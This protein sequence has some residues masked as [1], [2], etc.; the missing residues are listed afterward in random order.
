V[1]KDEP[2]LDRHAAKALAEALHRQ[3]I[4]AATGVDPNALEA[5]ALVRECGGHKRALKYLD[6]PVTIRLRTSTKE[7]RERFTAVRQWIEDDRPQVRGWR[8]LLKRWTR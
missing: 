3:E 4:V 7:D 2:R 5:M 8:R 6:D 1:G